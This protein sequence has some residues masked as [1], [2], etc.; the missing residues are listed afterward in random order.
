MQ[1]TDQRVARIAALN[2]RAHEAG[3]ALKR[4]T[5]SKWSPLPSSRGADDIKLAFPITD[6]Q[7]NSLHS[8]KFGV[9]YTV[10]DSSSDRG[11]VRQLP[12]SRAGLLKDDFASH[13]LEAKNLC[14]ELC[15]LVENLHQVGVFH[16]NIDANST[17]ILKSSR[18]QTTLKFANFVHSTLVAEEPEPY[19]DW[20]GVI[21]VFKSLMSVRPELSEDFEPKLLA[22]KDAL[23]ASSSKNPK[24]YTRIVGDAIS[25]YLAVPDIDDDHESVSPACAAGASGY[26]AGISETLSVLPDGG[27]P[28]MRPSRPTSSMITK[29][30]PRK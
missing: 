23:V 19:K 10:Q 16:G 4:I 21:E 15:L 7:Y 12:V 25:N 29:R 17:W 22:A 3:I 9:V 20:L 30:P 8:R 28:I 26:S 14:M 5:M 1:R 24:E 13:L 6:S 18:G 2:N 27:K 11:T